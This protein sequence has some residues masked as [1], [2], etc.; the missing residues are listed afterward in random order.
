MLFGNVPL[1]HP[2]CIFGEKL[3]C[4]STISDRGSQTFFSRCL[5]NIL[6]LTTLQAIQRLQLLELVASRSASQNRNSKC[7]EP[8]VTD[9]PWKDGLMGQILRAGKCLCVSFTAADV[10]LPSRAKPTYFV[11]V[12]LS[13]FAWKKK[14][15][16]N[17][18]QT[19]GIFEINNY[20][21]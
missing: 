21:C 11:M 17:R 13:A 9:V 16:P 6:Y 1:S 2:D 15:S 8:A 19:E 20:F 7:A 18:C 4:K 12:E 5:L 10:Q 3:A 14:L